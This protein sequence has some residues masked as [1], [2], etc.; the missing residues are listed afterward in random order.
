MSYKRLAKRLAILVCFASV[1]VFGYVFVKYLSTPSQSQILASGAT[2][3]STSSI[4]M[5]NNTP[6]A[7]HNPYFSFTYPV[8]MHAYAAQTLKPPVLAAYSYGYRDIESWQL[9]V[10]AQTLT[11]SS[12]AND[13]S[14]EFRLQHP[15]QYQRSTLSIHGQPVT[16][17][18]DANADGFSKVAYILHGSDV[19]HVSLYGNDTY[20]T[21]TLSS[22][23]MQVLNSVAWS[24]N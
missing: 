3:S 12:L 22:V 2:A 8:A 14:Y 1:L 7:V 15:D 10:S 13:S 4:S 16:V 24:S 21:S 18:T 9:A 19:L 5:F 23:F 11:Q 6:V 17:M 20:G